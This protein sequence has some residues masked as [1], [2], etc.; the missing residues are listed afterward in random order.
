V[1]TEAKP[2]DRIPKVAIPPQ[3]ATAIASHR[4]RPEAIN[5]Y[6]QAQTDITITARRFPG[7]VGTQVLPPLRGL[8]EEWA[9][10]CSMESNTAMTRWLEDPSRRKLAAGIEEL[11]LEPSHLLLLASDTAPSLP[12][13]VFTHRVAADNVDQYLDW[14][15]VI[16]AQ[17]LY[18]GYLATEFFEPYGKSGEWVDIV[19]FDSSAH[20]DA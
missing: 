11:L 5:T 14:R 17:A 6:I 12:P 2:Q 20:L 13:M 19:R 18:P 1:E 3:P 15:R 10:I 9:A 16:V 8:Q 7:F 4:V